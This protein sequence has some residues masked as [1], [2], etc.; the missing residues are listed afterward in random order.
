[1]EVLKE[2]IN[3]IQ[4]SINS[5]GS[6]ESVLDIINKEENIWGNYRSLL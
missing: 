3:I 4:W 2:D 1:M 6:P 5:I